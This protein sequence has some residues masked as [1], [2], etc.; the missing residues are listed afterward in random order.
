MM[1]ATRE[2]L[3]S[4]VDESQ[5]NRTQQ[6]FKDECDVNYILKRFRRTGTLPQTNANPAVFAD[7]TV[8]DFQDAMNLVTSAQQEFDLLD[9]ST[10]ARFGNSPAALLEFLQNPDNF[11]E[12]QDLG[13]VEPQPTPGPVVP[14][15]PVDA[16][17][18]AS[19]GQPRAAEQAAGGGE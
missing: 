10:R 16:G 3:D 12:A 14:D 18:P 19:P 15:Q 7:V 6:Q 11:S 4:P 1:Q 9:S 2:Q 13:L 17:P 5:E 8:N